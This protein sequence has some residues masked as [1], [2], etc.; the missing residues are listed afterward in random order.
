M[1]EESESVLQV[2]A[3]EETGFVVLMVTRLVMA[4]GQLF[5]SNLCESPSNLLIQST[6]RKLLKVLCV[7]CI[8]PCNTSSLWSYW[9]WMFLVILA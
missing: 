5:Y 9:D 1:L 7:E 3:S 6:L 2:D 4:S 8:K